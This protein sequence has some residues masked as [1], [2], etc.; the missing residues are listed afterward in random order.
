LVAIFACGVLAVGGLACSSKEPSKSTYF[1]RT[2]SPILTTSCV[3]TNTGAGCHV[4]DA[5]GNALGNLD[6]SSFAG[7]GKR[8]DLLV[9]YGP[10]GQPSF[11]VKNVDPFAVEV[12]S[13]DGTKVSI[14]TDIKHAGGSV[15]DA[16][17]TAYQTLRRWIQ[18]GATENNTGVRPGNAERL[19]CATFVPARGDF[20]LSQ[21]PPRGDF[22]TFRDRVD[23]II[24]G[25][26][27]DEDLNKISCGA[28]NC[29][30]TLSNSLYFTCGQTPEQIRWNYLAAQE[31]LG[32]TTEQSELLRR[33]LA[34]AAGGAYHEGGVIF[35]SANDEGY[36]RLEQW[37]NEHGP[38]VSSRN[39]AGFTFFAHRV[40]PMLVKKGCMMMQ[41][42]SGSMFHDYRLHGGSGGSFSLS[43]TRQNYELS[44][45][46]M[47][48]ESEDPNASRMVRKNLYRPDVCGVAGCDKPAG[49]LH[50]GG[51]L[52][53]DF[54]AQ[55][56]TPKLCADANH[57]YDKGDLNKIP[58]Y[59]VLLEW[60]KRERAQH[61]LAPLSAIVYVRRP[62]GSTKRA[63][64]FDVYSPGADLRRVGATMTDGL[65][66]TSDTDT[67]L[68]AGCGLDPATAD[69]RRPQVSWDGTRIA[70][71]ARASATE[72][73]AV[74]E[75][76]ADG[77]ACGKHPGINGTP[78]SQNGILIH[79][80]D[81]T[82]A[83]VEGGF[84][85]IVFASTRGNLDNG[86]FDYQGP[87]RTPADPS[88][89]NSNL[90]VLEAD[91]AAPVQTRV[92][93]LTFQ[94]NMER[95]PSF[96]NDG[97]VIFTV[98][99]RAPEFYQLALRR[100]NIDTGDYHPLYA[101]R[102]SIGYPEATQVVELA[103]KD[104]ATIFSN[105][106]GNGTGTLGVFNR[107]I[108]VD[109][110]STNPADYP[111]DKGVLDPGLPQ[112]PD[113]AFFLR[114]SRVPDPNGIYASPAALPG[115]EL[116]VSF[117]TASDL[118]VYAMD[119]ATGA[120]RK[121]FGQSGSSEVEAV[122]VYTRFPRAIFRSTLDE[123][124]GHTT[125][126]EGRSEAEI[127]VL[128]MPVLA[129]LL[130][131]N[132]PTGRVV[133]RE[134]SSITVYEDLPPTPEVD[135]MDKGG[136]FVANDAFGRVYVRRRWIGTAPLE[137]DG[138]IKLRVP[139][140]VPIVLELPETKL[141]K[142]RGLPR[143]QREAMSFS[144]GEYVHQSFREELFGSL[145]GQCHGS[146]SGRAVD[147]ALQ[148]DFVTHASETA[149]RFKVP[150]DMN[151]APSERK[152]PIKGP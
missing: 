47:A 146:I 127:H 8:R 16:S 101:Q 68:T 41:C 55:R 112:F 50:R 42:H 61:P 106:G 110:T 88:K 99:K 11:L 29:H 3:R 104:F 2:I 122:A 43:A 143:V 64:D 98:E 97:R 138:S 86:A 83:P 37:A 13:Y 95:Q 136:S 79:N 152:G 130:F 18:N 102:G 30:G 109:F 9:D 78:P 115:T 76:N 145:C 62:A 114:S 81:P 107:S 87:Q 90:Y 113:P 141:S 121:L 117:G 58:A 147:T 125:I 151:Q 66:A 12:Q 142:E 54:G 96:M 108:G 57:D 135:S 28:G 44:L 93:Q 26:A 33:P 25:H 150:F 120:K 17:G 118:D 51:P 67:S 19:A 100:I 63:Q 72:P 73:L 89:P 129:S 40:Q 60:L 1:D 52:L 111:V 69:I 144:P 74:Y 128:D 134:M 10:Y 85:R 24:G 22:A 39:D 27:D 77:S 48:I 133:D 49:I 34:P 116:L 137:S 56:A 46:Q 45:A 139:G 94:L 103:D 38:A 59:C 82:Y 75:M 20:D 149:A 70:F 148:P 7:V 14:T 5:R 140:G 91:P 36:R 123:P 80:F 92:R 31:Y 6:A 131:Q 124:N 32:A 4:A 53:E 21:D 132:T 15:L 71:A 105:P 23:P 35:A 119:A 84:S 65:I 126:F